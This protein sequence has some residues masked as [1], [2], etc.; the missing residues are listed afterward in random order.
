MK[1]NSSANIVPAVSSAEKH[2]HQAIVSL[3]KVSKKNEQAREAIA[4][5]SVVLL[6][7]QSIEKEE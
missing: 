7:L 1:I 6:D 2:I 3:G 5:L 4:N